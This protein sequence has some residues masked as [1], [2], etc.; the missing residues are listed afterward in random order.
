MRASQGTRAP[1]GAAIRRIVA[2][3]GLVLGLGLGVAGASAAAEPAPA[4]APDALRQH[5][6]LRML[7]QDCGSC[8]GL[9]LTGGLGPALTREALAGKPVEALAATIFHGRAG[10]PM[11]PWR[12]FVDEAE[13]RW[14]AAQLL[15]GLPAESGSAST[16]RPTSP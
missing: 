5:A 7:R 13:S 11:P 4:S 8:H 1:A 16:A 9:H 3:A 12:G 2:S 14:L 6:I 15:A 10:T